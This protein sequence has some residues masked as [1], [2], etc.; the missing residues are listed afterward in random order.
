MSIN[1]F[2]KSFWDG[3]PPVEKVP[4][5]DYWNNNPFNQPRSIGSSMNGAG[6]ARSVFAVYDGE[7]NQ[8]EFGPAKEYIKDT[9]TLRIRSKQ[10]FVESLVARGIVLKFLSWTIGGGL[11]LK[12]EPK[13]DVLKSEGITIDSE[14][15]NQTFEEKWDVQA[16]SNLMDYTGRG[17][18]YFLQQQAYLEGKL[19]GDVLVILRVINGIVKIQ[20]IDAGHVGN[21]PNC[22]VKYEDNIAGTPNNIGTEYVYEPTQNRIRKGVEM[23]A[24]GE[25]VAYH[26]R[27]GI[28]NKYVRLK[29]KD[30]MGFTRVYMYYGKR[31]DIDDTRGNGLLETALENLKKLD[32]YFSANLAAAETVA[33]FPIFFEHGTDSLEDD[34]T[35]GIRAKTFVG[36]P[37]PISNAVDTDIAIDAIG[38]K[39]A[40]DVAV[41]M[42]NT[43]VNLPRDVKAV[44]LARKQE[45]YSGMFTESIIDVTCMGLE[46]PP[47]VAM[48]KFND[49]F[50]ASRMAGMVW[51]HTFLADRADFAQQYCNPPKEL[52]MYIWVTATKIQAPGYLQKMEEE[53]VLAIAAYNHCR[54]VGSMFPDVDPLKTANYF[55]IMMGTGFEHMPLMTPP[56]AAELG[57]QGE[58]EAIL[59]ES[60]KYKDMAD[61]L[62]IED[63]LTRGETVDGATGATTP[64]KKTAKKKKTDKAKSEFL[65]KYSTSAEDEY[66]KSKKTKNKTE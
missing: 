26:V 66:P 44:S 64:P 43:V 12:T 11:V 23:N 65:D 40:S 41:T 47:N 6:S 33:K 21:P 57:G 46:I 59:R 9:Y 3:T 50:S 29:A 38:N 27:V 25:Y 15:F 1:I 5:R 54:W 60:A 32:R 13:K 61:D 8:G 52:Q 42:N 62:G 63:I 16:N 31:L 34:P 36:Q 10:L 4:E 2:S 18:F 53:N 17:N 58:Y 22:Q 37:N 30:S 49:S 35:A 14:A 56:T 55:R 51:Q 19:T 20:H 7:I 28:M 48:G 45:S 39:I 24:K